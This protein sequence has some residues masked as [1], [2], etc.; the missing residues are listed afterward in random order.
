MF[1]VSTNLWKS[2]HPKDVFPVFQKNLKA[3]IQI[4]PEKGA[5]E[6]FT[7]LPKKCALRICL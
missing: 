3:I 4:S 2:E 5:A 7:K 1:S 6:N